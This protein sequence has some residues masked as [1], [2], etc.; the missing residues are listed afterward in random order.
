MKT[1]RVVLILFVSLVGCSH[2]HS[3]NQDSFLTAAGRHIE[4]TR[5][6]TVWFNFNF[7]NRF[8]EEAR[9]A[10][11]EECEGGTVHGV[12]SRLSSENG[13]FF[14]ISRV[15]FEGICVARSP[16][17]LSVAQGSPAELGDVGVD[18]RALVGAEPSR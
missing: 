13:M 10:F 17:G 7:D 5:E 1:L 11:F 6:K 18:Q 2:V 14:W 15:H 16:D 12:S 9:T 3:Y 4:L 8:I